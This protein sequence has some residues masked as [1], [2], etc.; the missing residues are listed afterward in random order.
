M[1][2]GSMLINLLLD[3]RTSYSL[4][5]EDYSQK[6]IKQQLAWSPTSL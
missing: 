2:D 5:N 1:E 4:H 6:D 3:K